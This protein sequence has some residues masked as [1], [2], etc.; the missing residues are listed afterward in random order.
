MN[1]IGLDR[2]RTG[3][4]E[5]LAGPGDAYA[6]DIPTGDL[7]A[8]T[9]GGLVRLPG[10]FSAA[11][12]SAMVD[13]IWEALAREHGIRRDDRTTWTVVQPT[14][15]QGLTRT[16]AFRPIAAPG[17][18]AALERALG[19]GGWTSP[20]HWGAPLVTFPVAAASW[21]VP[22]AAWHLDFPV[23]GAWDQLPGLRIL[24]FPSTVQ[25]RGGGTVVAAGSHRL[26]ERLL[27]QGGAGDGRSPQIRKTLAAAH[28]W[29]VG[30]W[31]REANS[32][33][34]IARF[35]AREECVDDVPIRVVELTGEPGDVILMHPWTFHAAA[36]NCSATP[37]MM[38]SHSVFRRAAG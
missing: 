25:P 6:M 36:S 7:S 1:G 19:P 35:M 2:G 29:L 33:D 8:L 16:D 9:V 4:M 28:P 27:Q 31:S 14:G 5:V 12:A 17:V 22:T 23:R 11:D 24:A 21:N 20:E 30:L 15:F 3:V 10:A 34:R 26:V 18:L 37:R 38:I 32:Q 13:A